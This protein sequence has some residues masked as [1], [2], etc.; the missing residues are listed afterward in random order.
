MWSGEEALN[1]LFKTTYLKQLM[2]IPFSIMPLKLP[3]LLKD[4]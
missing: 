2:Q 4:K 1:N 3:P